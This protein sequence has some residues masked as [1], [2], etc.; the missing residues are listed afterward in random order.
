M[1]TLKMELALRAL[2]EDRA[3]RVQ[4]IIAAASQ[5]ARA[6]LCHLQENQDKYF[7]NSR[8]ERHCGVSAVSVG[9]GGDHRE[10][11]FHYDL[12]RL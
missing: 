3:H 1:F 5:R 12:T 6:S 9:I 11:C 10:N 2:Q 4:I 7:R 8:G